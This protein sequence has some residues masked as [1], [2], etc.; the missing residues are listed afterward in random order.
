MTSGTEEASLLSC[1][2]FGGNAARCSAL[3]LAKSRL[4]A[5]V[6][7]LYRACGR[8]YDSPRAALRAVARFGRRI[9]K[10]RQL[11]SK[12]EK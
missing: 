10:S 11:F 1:R 6:A 8:E 3:R 12:N 4:K 9:L 7:R 5:A 2:F